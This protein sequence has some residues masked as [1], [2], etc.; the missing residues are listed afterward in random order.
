LE[1][2]DVKYFTIEATEDGKSTYG[3]R[4]PP[5]T[6]LI[7]KIRKRSMPAKIDN[8]KH[9]FIRR[10]AQINMKLR[11]TV[12]NI[13][14]VG[15]RELDV[16]QLYVEVVKR[17]GIRAVCDNKEWDKVKKALKLPIAVTNAVMK[18]HYFTLLYGYEQ[19][20]FRG[21][22]DMEY[23]PVKKATSSSAKKA[24]AAAA[25]AKKEAASSSENTS[26]GEESS[27]ENEATES[28]PEVVPVVVRAPP[29]AKARSMAAARARKRKKG[30]TAKRG[31]NL[32]KKHKKNVT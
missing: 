30:S 8:Y 3:R 24:A 26:S 2:Y 18:R 7:T 31:D 1:C 27:S 14:I 5:G 9:R 15:A 13:P 16:C 6:K 11:V 22:P 20:W 4:I 32:R 25:A 23:I 19:R 29:K 28:E 10:L 17:G 12:K 21:G